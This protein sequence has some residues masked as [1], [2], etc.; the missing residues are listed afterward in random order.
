MIRYVLERVAWMVPTLLGISLVTFLLLDVM[1]VDAAAARLASRTAATVDAEARA[2]AIREIRI[3][4]GL[5]DPETGETRPFLVRWSDWVGRTVCMDIAPPG[6]TSAAF[7]A[8][9]G[10]AMLT[11]ASLG[12]TALVLALLFAVLVGALSG[13]AVGTRADPWLSVPLLLLAALPEFLVATFLLLLLPV[14]GAED[15]PV[16]GLSSSG[17]EHA[18]AV[19]RLVDALRHALLPVV[20]LAATPAVW[21]ARLVRDAVGRTRRS[22][23]VASQRAWGVP[24]FRIAI[25]VVGASLRPIWTWIGTSLPML[26]TATVVVEQVFRI[27]GIG[28]ITWV[29]V[30]QRDVTTVTVITLYTSILVLIALVVADVGQRYDDR[31]VRLG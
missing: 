6:E 16:A 2:E 3:R 5:V 8:R 25:A 20:V 31:R 12:L 29:A 24:G 4:N 26:V 18:S 30:V 1:P 28:R 19:D 23:W 11:S 14:L 15:W 27:P 9:L 21:G 10:R 13:F 7:R 17:L 22:E